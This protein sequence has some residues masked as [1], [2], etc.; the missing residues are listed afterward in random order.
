MTESETLVQVEKVGGGAAI[1]SVIERAATDPNVDI[2]KMERLLDMHH[3]M[4]DRD[5]EQQFNISMTA[6]QSGM[7]AVAHNSENKQTSSNYA[8]LAAI[9]KAIRPVYTSNGFSLSFGTDDCPI[10]D[11]MRVVCDVS[12][13]GGHTRRYQVDMPLDAAGIKGTPNKTKTHAHGSTMSYS[14]RYLTK[15]IFN[16]TTEDDDGNAAGAATISE[17]QAKNIEQLIVDV[18]IE[19]A[20]F[21]KW[22]E[23]INVTTIA[24]IPESQLDMVLSTLES[25]RGTS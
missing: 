11:Y 15:L 14:Q 19:R 18:G 4:I 16:L 20:K 21:M 2:D 13:A 12:H 6:A 3:Q 1:L 10:P 23:S 7:T 24:D 22:L 25:K 9:D 17:Q 5:A 8:D